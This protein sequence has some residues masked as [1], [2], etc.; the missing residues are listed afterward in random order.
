MRPWGRR[1]LYVLATLL[2]LALGAAAWVKVSFDDAR[3]RR[4]AIEWMRANHARELAFDGPIRLQLWPQPAVTVEDVR[5]SEPGRPEQRF[6]ALQEAALTLRLGPLLRRREV[7]VDR[8]TAR[9]LQVA[10]R[11]DA[12]GQNNADDLLARV[13]SGGGRASQPIVIDAVE[14]ADI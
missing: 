8:V 11:R 4:V 7:E 5:L 1:S 2:L 13:T 3:F 14:L 9:G 10:F 6:A 12:S